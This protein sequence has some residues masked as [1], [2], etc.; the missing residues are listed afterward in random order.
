MLTDQRVLRAIE[1]NIYT[2][3]KDIVANC[4]VVGN[5]RPFP[6]LFV[7]PRIPTGSPDAV[8]ELKRE[9]LERTSDFHSLRYV[10]WHL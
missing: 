8:A 9:I 6:A 3:C 7:E 2:T 10:F 5:G 1:D 4:V